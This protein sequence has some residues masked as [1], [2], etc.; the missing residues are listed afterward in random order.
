MKQ[1]T[2]I[3]V[4]GKEGCGKSGTIKILKEELIKTYINTSYTYTLPLPNGDD[5]SDVLICLGYKVGIESMGDYLRAGGLQDRLNDYVLKHNCD[6]IICAS[7]VYNDVSKHIKHLADTH[8]YRLIKV[9]NYRGDN[10]PFTP[11]ELN[12]LSAIHIAS[13]ANQ[14]LI[15]SI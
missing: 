12:Q 1:K 15:G 8:G 13:L 7:R 11:D 14:I 2:I 3:Q 10:P 4:W 5:I 6:V 9:T